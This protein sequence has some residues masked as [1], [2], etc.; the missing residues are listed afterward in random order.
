MAG[1][2]TCPECGSTVDTV[3][4]ATTSRILRVSTRRVRQLLGSGRFP[5]AFKI[6]NPPHY[7]IPL[8]DVDMVLT[9]RGQTI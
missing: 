2:A 6:G 9:E 1:T 7:R 4:V 8:A 3:D 5:N